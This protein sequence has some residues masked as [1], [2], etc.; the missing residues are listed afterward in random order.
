LIPFDTNILV[1]AADENSGERHLFAANLVRDARDV[2]VAL[3]EQSIL[4]FVNVVTKKAKLPLDRAIPYVQ[5]LLLTFKLICPP[6]TIVT[7][8]FALIERYNLNIFD[9]RIVAVC[10]AHG[11]DHLLSED[12]QDGAQYGG[13]TVVN[14]FNAANAQIIGQLLS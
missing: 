6:E 7:D 8:V 4:E 5:E 3:T 14:P 13:V 1:Y 9:A 10:A 12:L 2:P 11:C